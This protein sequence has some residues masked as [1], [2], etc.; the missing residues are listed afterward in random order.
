MERNN[1]KISNMNSVNFKGNVELLTPMGKKLDDATKNT[2]NI[3]KTATEKA[4]PDD[5]RGVITVRETKNP[6]ML[7]VSTYSA[8]EK[9]NEDYLE[10]VPDSRF[11]YSNGCSMFLPVTM[12]ETERTKLNNSLA[13]EIYSWHNYDRFAG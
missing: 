4:T 9:A 8:N 7:M 3:I 12:S 11:K 6:D 13:H 2:L 1:M 5:F 10:Q